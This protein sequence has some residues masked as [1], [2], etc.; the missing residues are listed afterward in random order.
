MPPLC[1][2]KDAGKLY[3]S[4]VTNTS[5]RER[6]IIEKCLDAGDRGFLGKS[7]ANAIQAEAIPAIHQWLKSQNLPDRDLAVGFLRNLSKSTTSTQDQEL[8]KNSCRLP[9]T[10]C[11]NSSA[12]VSKAGRDAI[13][14]Q[15]R[16]MLPKD[17]R[18]RERR[19]PAKCTPPT[20]KKPK[21]SRFPLWP[22]RGCVVNKGALFMQPHRCLPGHFEIHPEFQMTV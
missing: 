21:K 13:S 5:S 7:L 19:R 4:L 18:M 22:P 1:I 16:Q 11:K 17:D 9:P 6:I 10:L 15:V 3:H 14:D 8:S 12:E 2:S 20:G